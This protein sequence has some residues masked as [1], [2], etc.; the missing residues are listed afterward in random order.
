MR[1]WQ[2]MFLCILLITS[3]FVG[4]AKPTEESEQETTEQ[5]T[6]TPEATEQQTQEPEDEYVLKVGYVT[7][8][9]EI[10]DNRFN[11]IAWEGID[12]ACEEL[13]IE[14]G[15]KQP[16]NTEKSSYKSIIESMIE[17]GY[18]F[19]LSTGYGFSNVIQE[20]QY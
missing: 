12:S 11:Q 20:L 18:N 1:K 10:N 14:Y 19:I 3:A 8:S 5:A 6:P 16:V 2:I 9:G 13:E 4:C 17:E 7:D 15:Y